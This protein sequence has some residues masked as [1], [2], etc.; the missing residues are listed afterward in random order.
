[1]YPKTPIISPYF[2]FTRLIDQTAGET[3][4]ESE[5]VDERGQFSQLKLPIFGFNRTIHSKKVIR[6]NNCKKYLP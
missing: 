3:P 1:M 5:Y 6:Q 4:S 2:E